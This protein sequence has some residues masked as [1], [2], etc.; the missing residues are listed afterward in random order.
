MILGSDLEHR[1]LLERVPVL[2]G[3]SQRL[4]RHV[5]ACIGSDQLEG[6]T[7]ALQ[8]LLTGEPALLKEHETRVK[9]ACANEIHEVV[10]V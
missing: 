5:A 9:V 3:E 4:V 2:A 8:L 7:D 10:N 1:Y 6:T